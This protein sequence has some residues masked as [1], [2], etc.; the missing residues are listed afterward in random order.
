MSECCKRACPQEDLQQCHGTLF[1]WMV[2]FIGLLMLNEPCSS[3]FNWM[4]FMWPQVC[5]PTPYGAPMSH[6]PRLR[7][8]PPL[9]SLVCEAAHWWRMNEGSIMSHFRYESSRVCK[10]TNSSGLTEL[11]HKTRRR[12]WQRRHFPHQ[13]DIFSVVWFFCI[14]SLG[15]QSNLLWGGE[16]R[17]PKIFFWLFAFSFF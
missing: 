17:M 11:A 13:A 16:L 14:L 9:P 3:C 4:L 6:R 10:Q 1:W 7:L 2:T 12:K 8:A 5:T 15:K